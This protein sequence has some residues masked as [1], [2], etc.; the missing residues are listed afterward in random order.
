MYSPPTSS[1]TFY[2]TRLHG[3]DSQ[4][5]ATGAEIISCEGSSRANQE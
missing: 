2:S 1:G 5:I 4:Y 3:A